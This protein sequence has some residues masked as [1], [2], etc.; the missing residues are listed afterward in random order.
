M[1]PDIYL[2]AIILGAFCTLG[3]APFDITILFIVG[4]A[5]VY[6]ILCQTLK[7]N[8]A[9]FLGLWF[10]FA[11]FS[12]SFY[13]FGIALATDLARFWW[14]IPIAVFGLSLF[15]S[16]YFAFSFLLFK[17]FRYQNPFT[18]ALI[19]C[20]FEFL[21]AKLFS[22][23]PW[24]LAGYAWNSLEI[25]QFASIFGVYGLSFL[26]FFISA[27]VGAAVLSP[28]L[29]NKLCLFAS[30]LALVFVFAFGHHRLKN[31]QT[32]YTKKSVR[33]VQANIGHQ[34]EW[35]PDY[36]KKVLDEYI[37][38]TLSKNL[39]NIDYV[40]W[41]ESS[42][43]FLLAKD[44]AN[45]PKELCRVMPKTII[46]G[47]QRLENNKIFNTI[48]ILKDAKIIDHYDKVKLV[49]FGEYVPLGYLL[50]LKKLVNGLT[51]FSFGDQPKKI[52]ND[53]KMIPTVCYEGI[54]SEALDRDQHAEWIANLTNDSWFGISSGPYQHLSMSRLRAIEYGLPLV[55]STTTGISA[56]FDPY[57]R[58]L[59][60]IGMDKRQIADFYLPQK[61]KKMT[62]Y[63][64]I[65]KFL[66]K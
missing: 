40:V 41:P 20:F 44:S 53:L 10:G 3:F 17:L 57:G 39:N 25:L 2:L 49:P 24:N 34:A 64:K 26:I 15:F 42:I 27:S 45:L 18:F 63:K 11:H 55:R 4:F 28:K 16:L 54:F 7:K 59:K 56:V 35:S 65:R 23:F 47:A 19:V 31:N 37:N 61:A 6:I 46:A 33:I 36:A 38:L 29:T 48:F 13:W 32:L 30:A 5:F 1:R 22:G 66:F 21:R 50:P 51:G 60:S 12:T 14:V 52:I 9:F 8:Q 43:P 58:M 62:I